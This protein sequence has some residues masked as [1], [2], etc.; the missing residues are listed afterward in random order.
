MRR[1]LVLDR[2]RQRYRLNVI[3]NYEA[4]YANHVAACIGSLALVEIRQGA[5]TTIVACWRCCATCGTPGP[6]D[7]LASARLMRGRTR[8]DGPGFR[9]RA[10]K[11]TT[12]T[13]TDPA[14]GNGCE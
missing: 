13:P 8:V 3:Q 14:A 5:R 4:A 11:R 10:A 6:S 12:S 2:H 1:G 7:R 9:R